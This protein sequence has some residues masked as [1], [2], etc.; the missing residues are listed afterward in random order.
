MA[1]PQPKLARN[2]VVR[3]YVVL[4]DGHVGS[5]VGLWP[6]S[7]PIEGGGLYSCNEYQLWLAKCWEEMLA[8]V[9]A[10]RPRPVIIFNGD[11]IQGVNYKDGQLVTP[12]INIQVEAAL[13]LYA[14]LRES[15]SRWY[16]IRGTEWHEGKASEHVEL[17]ASRLG[18]EKDPAS[19]QWSWWELYLDLEPGGGGPVAHFAHHVGMSSVPW[20]EATVPLRDAL[21][22]LA[23]LWRF[24]GENAPNVRMVVRSHRHRNIYVVAP[25]DI[26][27]FVTP[28]WQLKTAF[29]YKKASSMLPQIGYVVV[30][31][32]GQEIVVKSR[33][34]PLPG[35]HVEVV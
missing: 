10:M 6:G 7:H 22:E 25:P 26:H 19:G 18:A 29:S 31:W 32:D 13:K 8:E 17:L 20:Y 30:E 5:T 2:R 3:R 27:V 15:A 24:Y 23:E 9:R 35:L 4:S 28:A 33:I 11:A 16:Q 12:N 34:F 21:L 14:P 1:G